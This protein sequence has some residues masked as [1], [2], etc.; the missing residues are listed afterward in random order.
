[1]TGMTSLF[2]RRLQRPRLKLALTTVQTFCYSLLFALTYTGHSAAP[3]NRLTPHLGPFHFA[4]HPSSV[5]PCC[6]PIH[7]QSVHLSLFRLQYIT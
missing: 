5:P 3:F 2:A 7:V 1:M 4:V 6:C